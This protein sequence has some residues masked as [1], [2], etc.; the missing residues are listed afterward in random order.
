[1][2]KSLARI[3]ASLLGMPS[4]VAGA[5]VSFNLPTG[6]TFTVKNAAGGPDVLIVNS[7]GE[8]LVNGQPLSAIVGQ[9]G[10][11][12][13][14]GAKGDTGATGAT[15][16]T[17]PQGSIGLTG[18]TGTQGP[19]GDTGATGA[20]GTQ[21][22]KG[23]I[24]A[25]GPQ[26]SVGPQGIKGDKGDTGAT[27]EAGAPGKTILSGLAAPTTEGTL[28]DYYLDTDDSLFYGP[29]TASGWGLGVSLIG[30]KGD[31]GD[32]GPQG[33]KG[34]TGATGATGPQGPIGLTGATGEQGAKGDTGAAGATGA[35]GPQ[36]P[37]G[38]AGDA[39]KADA[40]CFSDDTRIADCGNG[41][42][43]D[44][45]TGLVWLKNPDCANLDSQP[46]AAASDAAAILGDGDCGLTDGSASGDW[47]LPSAEEWEWSTALFGFGGDDTLT[48]WSAVTDWSNH[49]QALA[50]H[51]LTGLTAHPKTG[52]Y[53]A[54]PVRGGHGLPS[55][56]EAG[57]HFS[58]YL[59]IGAN[60]DIIKD[61]VTGY[62]W[63]RCSVGQS[64]NASTAACEGTAGTYTWYTA[65]ANWPATAEWR[66]PTI[67]ELRTLVYCSSGTPI[68]F[69]MISNYTACSGSYQ[70]PTILSSAFPNTNG[71]WFWS[72]S[73]NAGNS[74][75]AWSVYFSIG[76]V[77]DNRGKDN[78]T[79]VR[80]VRGGQ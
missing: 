49:N 47:R 41:T 59:P 75:S 6:H 23:D 72:S 68:L 37:A 74:V 20:T 5:N 25:T 17:G 19:K 15:G 65:M 21:G 24:G 45:V 4:V 46:W 54:W 7:N 48:Y 9:T 58:R 27:G 70:N 64:W 76:Y 2:H 39:I 62:E 67:A 8:L 33:A 60:G 16:A 50:A 79:Y 12:G 40:P 26:G 22:P 77:N 71:G 14:Q 35:A 43:T 78:A 66:L 28:G 61:Q 31:E 63:Q 11:Q 57:Q 69:D 51:I 55:A 13:P 1:M 32:P 34:D 10:P 42:L 52:S 3:S 30:L 44:S 29:K 18:A 53:Q 38:P 80:L 56:A 36:G 73:P